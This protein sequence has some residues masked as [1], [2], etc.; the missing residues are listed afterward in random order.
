MEPFD[1]IG[2]H[3][4]KNKKAV[5]RQCCNFAQKERKTPISMS[6]DG[7]VLYTLTLLLSH[8]K[9]QYFLDFLRE[10][11]MSLVLYSHSGSIWPGN[12][13][14]K[15]LDWGLFEILTPSTPG[16]S[17]WTKIFSSKFFSHHPLQML[18]YAF[19]WFVL[20]KMT[21]F[22]ENRWNSPSLPSNKNMSKSVQKYLVFL[23]IRHFYQNKSTKC[24]K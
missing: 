16:M 18:F 9:Q 5:N 15:V 3:T 14:F 12:I 1:K 6:G 19:C 22:K 13:I 17:Q 21:N 4:V 11:G 24:I 7:C 20:V 8:T 23:E 2:A 10:P